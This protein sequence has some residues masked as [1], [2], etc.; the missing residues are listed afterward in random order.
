MAVPYLAFIKPRRALLPAL[1][2][3]LPLC[4]YREAD[5]R[6]GSKADKPSRA[7]TN[8]CPLW[9]NSGQSRVRL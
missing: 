3:N 6:F 8:F 2:R 9:S 7:K 5:V 4:E 1:F